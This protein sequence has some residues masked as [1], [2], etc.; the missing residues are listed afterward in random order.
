M[1]ESQGHSDKCYQNHIQNY[2][3]F[4]KNNGPF[5]LDKSPGD[6]IPIP[7]GEKKSW[8]TVTNAITTPDG[9][10]GQEFWRQIEEYKL[11]Q[12]LERKTGYQYS[13][14]DNFPHIYEMVDK[15]DKAVNQGKIQRDIAK[16]MSEFFMVSKK[17]IHSPEQQHEL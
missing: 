9:P 17:G 8:D 5:S 11:G 16:K 2:K 3:D 1:N 14:S 4:L 6:I 10:E 15:Y 7:F 12:T 13:K